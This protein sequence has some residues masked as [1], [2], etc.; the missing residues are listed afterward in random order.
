MHRGFT[1][2]ELLIVM[3]M[4]L[5][6]CS[7]TIPLVV[8]NSSQALQQELEKLEITLLYLQQKAMGS[9]QEQQLLFDVLTHSYSY[10][11][12]QKWVRYTLPPE[13]QIGFIPA[14]LGPPSHP[15]IPI[16]SPTTFPLVKNST[17]CVKSFQTGNFSPGSIY[18][19][20]KNKKTMGALTCAISQVS[21][22]RRYSY[23][24]GQWKPITI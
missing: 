14:A 23:M 8:K 1:L 18:F 13:I 5:I 3:M 21:Y 15:T 17:F 11:S 10:M 4:I 7:M 24:N 2:F 16:T 19:I 6:L 12:H 9:D 22:I 20:D